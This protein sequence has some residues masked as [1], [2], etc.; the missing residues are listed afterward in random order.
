MNSRKELLQNLKSTYCRIA[1]SKV[2]GVGILAIRD[3]PKGTNPFPSV[4]KQKWVKFNIS[5]FQNADK[6]V[7][8]L[9]D[10]FFVIQK[11]GSFWAWDL[12]LNGMEPSFY[13]NHSKKP[14]IKAEN[15]GANFRTLRKIKKGE[16]LLVSYGTY[17]YKYK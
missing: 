3:I 6:A 4:R 5:E 11:D 12:G 13:I 8:E 7:L 17:D 16:E 2:Q 9:I 1:P 14:N 10:A 15:N